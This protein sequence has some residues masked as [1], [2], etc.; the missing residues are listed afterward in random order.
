MPLASPRKSSTSSGRAAERPRPRYLGLEVA[1]D[2]PLL[3][4]PRA[5]EAILSAR[6]ARGA[7][8]PASGFRIVRSDGRRAIVEVE[9]RAA[10]WARAAWNGPDPAGA[11]PTIA[12]RRTWGT[13]VDAKVWMRRPRAVAG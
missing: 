12:T 4:S 1:G 8:G 10:S 3:P 6:W 13:L 11:G 5:W 9:H 2:Q 7:R